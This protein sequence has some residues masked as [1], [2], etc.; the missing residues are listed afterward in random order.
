MRKVPRYGAKIT[1][2]AAP[3]LRALGDRI[4]VKSSRIR[5]LLLTHNRP[6]VGYYFHSYRSP[7]KLPLFAIRVLTSRV[8]PPC[9]T[10]VVTL[11][12]I[13]MSV[14]LLVSQ[15]VS[16]LIVC[17]PVSLSVSLVGLVVR[18]GITIY[19]TCF[20]CFCRC[21]WRAPIST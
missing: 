6:S 13:F 21:C 19:Y 8:H 18:F 15:S 11:L 14:C 5:D 4:A 12:Y 9:G 17:V 2:A 3:R 16:S 10:A 1:T 7:V 20:C